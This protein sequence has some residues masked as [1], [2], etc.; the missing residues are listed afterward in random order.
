MPCKLGDP[1]SYKRDSELIV[2]KYDSRSELLSFILKLLI[3]HF[4]VLKL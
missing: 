1:L 2:S 3:K 4:I